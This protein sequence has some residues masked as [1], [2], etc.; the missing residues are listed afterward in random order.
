[1][2]DRSGYQ[3]DQAFPWNRA[4]LT[5]VRALG[6]VISSKNHRSVGIHTNQSLDQTEAGLE[7]MAADHYGT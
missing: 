3:A 1:M 7:W 5:T 6:R 2:S 4:Q